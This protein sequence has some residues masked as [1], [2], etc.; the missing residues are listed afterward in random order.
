MGS[1]IHVPSLEFPANYVF[2]VNEGGVG[3]KS[4]ESS[5]NKINGLS[6]DEYN[7]ANPNGV[8]RLNSSSKLSSFPANPNTFNVPVTVN[9]PTEAPVSSTVDYQITNY[10]DFNNYNVSV[11]A[12]S[13]T[14]SKGNIKITTPAQIGR[15]FLTINGRNIP[16]DVYQKRTSPVLSFTKENSIYSLSGNA[17]S[18]LGVGD[19]HI[20]SH[21]EISRDSNFDD[22]VLRDYNNTQ[23]LTSYQ[24]RSNITGYYARVAYVGSSSNVTE[25]SNVVQLN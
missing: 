15:I 1:K 12:G 20:E 24:F 5:L 3:G 17:F 7:Q 16:I 14:R 25:W 23:K 9:G 22:I 6:M 4:K 21:W 11:S 19:S 18:P 13:F 10:S 2:A 8:M